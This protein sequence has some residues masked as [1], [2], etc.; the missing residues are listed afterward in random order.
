DLLTAAGFRF[1]TLA[2]EIDERPHRDE[3]PAAYVCRLAAEKSAATA[4]R[5]VS[6]AFS[7]QTPCASTGDGDIC[8]SVR[9]D[10]E[11]VVVLGA[12]TTVVVDGAILG[13]PS[14]A[15]EAASMLWAL[16]GRRHDVLTGVSLR[17]GDRHVVR[18]AT[19]HVVFAPMSTD[20]VA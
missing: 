17:R 18:L 6:P 14:G 9:G 2:V 10:G 4:A 20:D 15:V 5:L 13:R 12:D 1:E 11:D 16:S 19:T 3:R 7:A 8:R